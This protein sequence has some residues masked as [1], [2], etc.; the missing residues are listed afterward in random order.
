MIEE[1]PVPI[2]PVEVT[3]K[4]VHDEHVP[5]ISQQ[6]LRIHI[7]LLLDRIQ[8]T[9]QLRI[10]TAVRRIQH[11]VSDGAE[12]KQSAS[13]QSKILAGTHD[14]RVVSHGIGPQKR[15][16]CGDPD[17]VEYGTGDVLVDAAVRLGTA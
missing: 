13:V 17:H 5:K 12:V 15:F 7:L 10:G 2:V 8:N 6:F 1:S 3:Q 11:R 14:L 16:L 9:L 4:C